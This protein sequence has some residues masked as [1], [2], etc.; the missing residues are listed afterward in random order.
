MAARVLLRRRAAAPF[1][2]AIVPAVAQAEAPQDLSK[3]PI[4]DDFEPALPNARTPVPSPHSD[5]IP[6]SSSPPAP[7]TPSSSLS[8][9]SHNAAAETPRGPTPTDRLAVHIGRARLA[10]H[11]YVARGEDGVNAAVDRAFHLEQSL[12]ET[13]AS[14]APPRASGERLM[15]GLVYVLVASMAGSIVA[16]NRGLLLRAA[17]PLA[18]GTAAARLLLPV[19]THNVADLLW[20][21]EQRFPQVADAHLEARRGLDRGLRAAR[22]HADRGSAFLGDKVGAARDS[23]EDWVKQGK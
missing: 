17:A 20:R 2:A 23:V 10:L 15:P 9:F 14:L 19:T 5:T 8:A 1:L 11:R 7:S 13:V 3:K 22:A 12:T 6:S 21:Y 18:L 16:R 4:Y